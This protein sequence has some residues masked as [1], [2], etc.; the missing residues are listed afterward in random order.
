M[1]HLARVTLHGVDDRRA[2]VVL[3]HG[4]ARALESHARR[5][6]VHGASLPRTDHRDLDVRRDLDDRVEVVGSVPE[7]SEWERTSIE[8]EMLVGKGRPHEALALYLAAMDRPDATVEQVAAARIEAIVVALRMYDLRQAHGLLEGVDLDGLPEPART[9]A[10]MLD[11]VVRSMRGEGAAMDR[12]LVDVGRR[13]D[14]P[15][16]PDELRFIGEG[17]TLAIARTGRRDDLL[18][19]VLR[20]AGMARD[21]GLVDLVTTLLV[22]EA[23]YRSRSDLAGGAHVAERAVRLA[24]ATNDWRN[25]PFALAQA[26]NAHAG[27]GDAVALDDASTLEGFAAPAALMVAGFVRAMY[28]STIGDDDGAYRELL[29]LEERFADGQSWVVSWHADLVELAL[30]RGHIE[31]AERAAASVRDVADLSGM[32]W[33]VAAADRCGAMLT[34]DVD[35]AARL[36]DRALAGFECGGYGIS[37]ARTRLAWARRLRA[38]DDDRWTEIAVAAREGFERAGMGSWAVRCAEP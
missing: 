15:L 12:L 26:A 32:P 20:V 1:V 24:T 4:A 36:V 21:V 34:A 7:V 38:I 13:L 9:R 2:V 14:G 27:L 8:A 10:G 22:A 5:R 23:A 31:V 3:D 19:V 6:F 29:D 25:L 33:L 35:E 37:A 16:P 18:D 11:L 28:A 30:A 17:L